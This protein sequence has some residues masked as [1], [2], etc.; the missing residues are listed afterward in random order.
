MIVKKKDYGIYTVGW[1]KE[2][3]WRCHFKLLDI[4]MNILLKITAMCRL[5]D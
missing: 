2:A 5:N 4:A 3:I 1:T